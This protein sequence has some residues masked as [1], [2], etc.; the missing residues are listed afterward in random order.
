VDDDG[1]GIEMQR[2]WRRGLAGVAAFLAVAGGSTAAGAS[3]EP[4]RTTAEGVGALGE[5]PGAD[6]AVT[7]VPLPD[8]GI[9]HRR[10]D[11]GIYLF[12][13]PLSDLE[14]ADAY[15]VRSLPASSGFR[16]DRAKV[17]AGDFGD[18]TAGDDGTADHVIWHM[19]TDTGVRVY[20]IGGG[21]DTSPRLWHVLPHSAGWTWADTR[22]MSG[23][24]NG[25]GWDDLVVVHKGRTGGIVW[26]LLSDGAGL[27]APQRWGS[28]PGDFATARFSVADADGD[29]N[30][31]VI[32]TATV[33]G[34]S[35]S[36]STT[37]SP[38]RADGTGVVGTNVLARRYTSS[39]GWSFAN[40]RNLAGDVDGDGAADLVTVHRSSSGGLIVWVAPSCSSAPGDFCWGAPVRWQTLSGWSF[41]NSRQYLADTDGDYVEDL[42]TVH[43]AGNGGMY[44]WRHVSVGTAF[45]APEQRFDLP[46]SAA[47]NWSYSRESV[48]DTWGALGP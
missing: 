10:P 39:G 47:W 18:I 16:Y 22:P 41:A 42:V 45:A 35:T 8:L 48:A 29:G 6:P 33:G 28:L 43:R 4:Q 24:V 36:F 11:G 14:F 34:A 38:T 23:D 2:R 30:E 25:D 12:R 31:D 20:G 19:G 27:G 37:V 15:R 26:A 44:I 13:L 9:A 40:S 46:S 17:I 21:D 3:E 7:Y 1:T 5:P 32:S